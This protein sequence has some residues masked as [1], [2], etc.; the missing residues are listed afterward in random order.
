MISIKQKQSS[1]IRNLS[2]GKNYNEELNDTLNGINLNEDEND[3]NNYG[4]DYDLYSQKLS[5]S[6][7]YKIKSRSKLINI[8]MKD[9][10]N[11]NKENENKIKYKYEIDE[12]NKKNQGF[13]RN[14]YKLYEIRKRKDNIY[15]NNKNNINNISNRKISLKEYLL[16]FEKNRIDEVDG[17]DYDY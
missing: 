8:E 4:I 2:N 5:Y 1:H 17:S 13:V 3:K 15:Q 9:L 11:K 14:P 12:Y 10:S 7:L 6:S 16:S